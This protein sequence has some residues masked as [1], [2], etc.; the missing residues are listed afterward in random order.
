MCGL[1]E[2][3]S[4]CIRRGA[5]Q[6][7]AIHFFR[8]PFFWYHPLGP[9]YSARSPA[10]LALCLCSSWT[11]RILQPRMLYGAYYRSSRP[12]IHAM[13]ST[14]GHGMSWAWL[15]WA[16]LGEEAHA[17]RNLGRDVLQK[18]LVSSAIIQFS[19][20]MHLSDLYFL[21]HVVSFCTWTSDVLSKA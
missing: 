21:S 4:A 16:G 14:D 5:A 15:G 13:Q 17:W 6:P 2:E 18:G 12:C 7:R 11:S 8:R 9:A 1:F 19:F 10:M 3:L 20:I